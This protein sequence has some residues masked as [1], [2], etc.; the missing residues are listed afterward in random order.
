[1]EPSK[2]ILVPTP[3]GNLKDITLRALEVLKNCDIILAE[4]T[5]NTGIL[6]KYFEIEKP[7][8]SYHAHNE[9][10]KYKDVLNQIEQGKIFAL[11][12]DA[13]TP[14]ISDPGFLIVREC[15]K[16]NIKIECLPGATAFV[17]ALVKSGLPCDK[18]VFEG[19]MPVKKGRKT[20]FDLLLNEARTIVFY[21]SP[22]KL[23][24]LLQDAIKYLGAERKVSVTREISK[25]YEETINGDLSE[26][27]LHFKNKA[28]KGEFVVVLEGKKDA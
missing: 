13:G 22:Y 16:H 2:L 1:M 23:I 5:R 14:G 28:P 24:A 25:I 8:Q 11:V 9:H 18:F 7:M 6:L 21:E 10:E 27:L 3:V 17:P 19:F 15:I 12:T 20:R 26:V 4:D